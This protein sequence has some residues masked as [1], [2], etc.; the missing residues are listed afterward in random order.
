MIVTPAL[1][2]LSMLLR[3][4]EICAYPEVRRLKKIES[5]K[6][7]KKPK[8]LEVEKQVRS[9]LDSIPYSFPTTNI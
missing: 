6:T 3:P 8:K 2:L 9:S 1:L 5:R 7:W 4:I